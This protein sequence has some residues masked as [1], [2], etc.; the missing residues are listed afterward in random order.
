VA[1]STMG[2]GEVRLV[3]CL[4]I[5]LIESTVPGLRM[6]QV[7][8]DRFNRALVSQI[9]PHLEALQFDDLLVKFT[10]DGW[11]LMT[12]EVRDAERLC[13]LGAIMRDTFADE[14]RR[15]TGLP[16][17]RIPDLRMAI[18]A[19]RDIRVQLWEGSFDW[20]GDSARR[21]TRSASF[22]FPNEIL[23]DGAV[24]SLVMRDFLTSRID[25]GTRPSR[26]IARLEEEIPLWSLEDLRI[27]AV[28]DWD[29]AA[30]YVY[31][32]GRLGRLD[33]AAEAS[34]RAASRLV[35]VDELAQSPSTARTTQR[36]NRLIANAPTYESV[37]ELVTRLL[38]SPSRPDTGT[39]VSLVD[40]APTIEEARAWVADLRMQG[41]QPD[42][43]VYSTLI[44]RAPTVEAGLELLAEME[45]EGVAVTTG[46]VNLVVAKA[47]T[48]RAA[49][50]LLRLFTERGLVPDLDTFGRLVAKAPGYD[51]AVALLDVMRTSGVAAD[52]SIMNRIVSLAPDFETAAAWLDRMQEEAIPPDPGTYSILIARAPRYGAAL[53]LLDSMGARDV[54]PDVTTFNTLMARA[55][56]HGLAVGLL[57]RMERANVPPT[58]ETFKALIVRA[59]DYATAVGWLAE[60]GRRGVRPNN[61]VFKAL[62]ASAP[63]FEAASS[64]LGEMPTANVAPNAETFRTLIG[65]AP[66]FAE[67]A[68]LVGE[69]HRR[70][71]R[72]NEET[73]RTLASLADDADEREE[74]IAMLDRYG[75][76]ATA[77]ILNSILAKAEGWDDAEQWMT[78]LADL[79]VSPNGDTLT[80]L[81]RKTSDHE[82]ASDVWERFGS[83][84]EPNEGAYRALV[85]RAPDFATARVW[86]ERMR[87][88]GMRPEVGILTMLMQKD[89]GDTDAD[90]LLGWYLALDHHPSGPMKTAIE[91]YL[92]SGRTRDA[93]RLVL[94][95]PHLDEARAVFAGHPGESL[96][97]FEEVLEDDP[98]H[99][100]GRYAMGLALLQLGRNEEA[101]RHLELAREL[102]RPGPRVVALD[103]IIRGA[104]P[105]RE[106]P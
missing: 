37:L 25:P 2:S 80:V 6:T 92:A 13:A 60:M 40:R 66:R 46:V 84:V 50:T 47:L 61:E 81:L 55:P 44:R 85:E 3:Y 41:V 78:R 105:G 64:W 65:R 19:G 12:P 36:W 26:R 33:D 76:R 103:E 32:L 51:A 8:L 58:P 94:D 52:A 21:A 57:R 45:D 89:P 39:L 104:S 53:E 15:R 28:E 93:L 49:L 86:V 98:G 59:P 74:L 69:M 75:V 56:D 90:A 35:D 96:A 34:A 62:I 106:A 20:V 95:Y 29:A 5:D 67:G 24:Q 16:R 100:N 14:M 54:A 82:A 43:T 31:A 68:V 83:T 22:C 17:T 1:Q 79:S 72:P 97:Y 73:F 42:A 88:E 23:V 10:G 63:D 87:S 30:A 71:V 27:E 77:D 18:C 48:F 91:T 101:L 11:L 38:E 102:A 99:P 7:E 70:N 4:S 9:E